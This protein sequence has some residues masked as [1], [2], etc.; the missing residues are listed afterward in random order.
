MSPVGVY[1]SAAEILQALSGIEHH[2]ER[3]GVGCYPEGHPKISDEVLL[4]ALRAKQHSR[5][6]W[7]ASCASMWKRSEH[8]FAR[9][10]RLASIFRYI[11]DSRHR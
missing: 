4:E 8:G 6:T 3:I 11:S 7:S 2:L 9:R 5:T 10:A 1:S